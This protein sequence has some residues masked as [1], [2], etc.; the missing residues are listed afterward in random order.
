[1]V[2]DLQ[3]GRTDFLT[4]A[5]SFEP[6]LRE[7][8]VG[9]ALDPEW[10]LGPTE[11]HLAQVGHVGIA[12]VNLTTQWLANLTKQHKL[13]QKVFLLHQF[14]FDMIENREQ[15]DTSRSELDYVI[16]VDGHG[17]QQAKQ[18]TWAVLTA[19]PPP[20]TAFGWKNFYDEDLPMRSPQDTMTLQPVPHYISYQ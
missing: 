20:T 16:H 18:E 8:H 11:V 12:E 5:K 4:Q 13:P 2:L 10:R 1:M 6:L 9:L 19:A 7:P 17:T 15:L 3:P 14:R